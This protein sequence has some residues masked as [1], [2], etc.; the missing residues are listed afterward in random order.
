MR[1]G[2]LGNRRRSDGWYIWLGDRGGDG[3]RRV[4]TDLRK[5]DDVLRRDSEAR[6]PL[7][8]MEHPNYAK[9]G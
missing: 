3:R 8:G 7:A 6:L 1:G 9:A 4:G 2:L 5:V